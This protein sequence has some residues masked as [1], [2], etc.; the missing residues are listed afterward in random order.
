MGG[1]QS[2]KGLMIPSPKNERAALDA[3]LTEAELWSDTQQCMR[4]DA[5]GGFSL[6]DSLLGGVPRR[7]KCHS[8]SSFLAWSV[9]PHLWTIT[10]PQ[11]IQDPTVVGYMHVSRPRA[12]VL[13]NLHPSHIDYAT[14]YESLWPMRSFRTDG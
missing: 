14:I 4:L 9:F 2:F 13:T 1:I 10:H 12:T 5:S 6:L 3:S 8:Y 7:I 11:C